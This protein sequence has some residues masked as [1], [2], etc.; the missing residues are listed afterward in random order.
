ML[1]LW[2]MISKI[3]LLRLWLLYHF[4]FW[5]SLARMPLA[6][7]MVRLSSQPSCLPRFPW[8]L[9][10]FFFFLAFLPLT[11]LASFL[12]LA[13]LALP[14]DYW[15]VPDFWAL[16]NWLSRKLRL[17]VKGCFLLEHRWSRL[18][19]SWILVLVPALLTALTRLYQGISSLMLAIHSFIK[20]RRWS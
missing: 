7:V 15:A 4:F 3:S 2:Q 8:H 19:L 17:I 18:V 6:P 16:F 14:L 20:G 13:W 12:C 1:Q 9:F 5:S 10:L 11:F